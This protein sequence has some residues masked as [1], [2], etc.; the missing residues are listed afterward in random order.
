MYLQM[1]IDLGTQGM[2]IE[3]REKGDNRITEQQ[4]SKKAT[5][6]ITQ[7]STTHT[8]FLERIRGL[9]RCLLR[10]NLVGVIEAAHVSSAVGPHRNYEARV[11][12]SCYRRHE[13]LSRT[14]GRENEMPCSP[15]PANLLA[16]V[17]GSCSYLPP[18]KYVI[19]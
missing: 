13:F 5:G 9:W 2:R 14:V 15:V 3:K 7:H 16:L 6:I 1:G 4:E 19:Y 10:Q 8:S 11:V 17:A 12:F 18:T